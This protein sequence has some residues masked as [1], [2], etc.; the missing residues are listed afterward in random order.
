MKYRIVYPTLLFVFICL[1]PEL[2]AQT[3]FK[4]NA[5]TAPVLVPHAG[6]ETSL[7]DKWTFQTDVLGSFWK[8]FKG[9]P[10]QF[11]MLSAEARYYPRGV[12]SG[13]YAG[14]NLSGMAG[15]LSKPQY[16]TEGIYS[17]KGYAYMAGVTVGYVFDLSGKVSLDLFATGGHIQGRFKHYDLRT[18]LRTD[19]DENAGL[20]RSGE[21]FPYR[22]GAMLTF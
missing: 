3:R 4:F 20:N 17:Q 19:R 21:W 8:S 13:F 11:G 6:M 15:R 16:W 22:T 12:F 18:G 14:P 2:H 10:F 1:C 9:I 7:S 5:L